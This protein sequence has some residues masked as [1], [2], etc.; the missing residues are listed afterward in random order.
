[1]SLLC[2]LQFSSLREGEGEEECKLNPSHQHTSTLLCK[3]LDSKLVRVVCC[4]ECVC[5]SLLYGMFALTDVGFIEMFPVL[6]ATDRSL[7]G[8][9]FTTQQIGSSLMVV[10]LILLPLQLTL[11]PKINK[12]FGS[13]RLLIASNLLFAFLCPLLPSIAGVVDV[14][15]MWTCLLLLLFLL[16]TCVFTAYLSL[17]ILLNNS[18]PPINRYTKLACFTTFEDLFRLTYF[19]F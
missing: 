18:V 12:R 7:N 4:R 9:S 14:S 15:I 8:L 11:L 3:F 13:K 10:S 19:F 1:M 17:N 6:A 2:F 5:C 16:R